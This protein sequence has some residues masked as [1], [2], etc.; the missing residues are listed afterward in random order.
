MGRTGPKSLLAGTS[1][2]CDARMMAGTE[3][4]RPGDIILDNAMPN[5]T[6]EEREVARENLYAFAA[7]I[8]RICTRLAEE[9]AEAIRKTEAA[10]VNFQG[11]PGSTS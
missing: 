11:E 7:A 3:Q 4:R 10:E 5:A 1:T 8:L 9:E 2:A 6:H